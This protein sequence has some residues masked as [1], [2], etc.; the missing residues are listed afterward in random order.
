MHPPSPVIT[1]HFPVCVLQWTD[2]VFEDLGNRHAAQ[3]VL[4]FA[5]S[6]AL[7][8]CKKNDEDDVRNDDEGKTKTGVA[9][10]FV[11]FGCNSCV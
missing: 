8:T 9:G 11:V 1:H 10:E 7:F 3:T 4:D 2:I 6:R 5:H